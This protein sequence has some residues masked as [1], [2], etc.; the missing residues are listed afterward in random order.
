MS[1][2][3]GSKGV[4]QGAQVAAKTTMTTTAR[5]KS[6]MRRRARR[7]RVLTQYRSSW[8]GSAGRATASVPFGGAISGT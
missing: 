8:A 5:P 3:R 1:C 6:A 4:S 7:L 2:S